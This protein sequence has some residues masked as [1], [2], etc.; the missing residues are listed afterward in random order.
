METK[1]DWD[2]GMQHLVRKSVND[3]LL[4]TVKG[5]DVKPPPV[6]IPMVGNGDSENNKNEG[7]PKSSVTLPWMKRFASGGGVNSQAASTIISQLN[8]Y[9]RRSSLTG[10]V[11]RVGKK[12]QGKNEVTP[13]SGA[14]KPPWEDQGQSKLLSNPSTGNHPRDPPP[15]LLSGSNVTVNS[16]V[17]RSSISS[18]NSTKDVHSLP[19][20]KGVPHVYH[21]YSNVPDI[22]GVV[23]K[24]T[25][26]VTQPFPEKLHTMLDNNDDP[27]IVSWLPHGRAF[28]V[29]KPVEFTA[30]IMPK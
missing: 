29:R 6:T 26:G 30:Q 21:D 28:L 15:L 23:R 13:P 2:G 7:H 14:I 4:Q 12:L 5:Y 20:K 27:S 24:K 1:H 25:G 10:Q 18:T 16:S 3:G 8:N 9:H 22:V 17:G 11:D 19:T